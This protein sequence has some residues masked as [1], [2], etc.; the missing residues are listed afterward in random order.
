MGSMKKILNTIF[1]K[2]PISEEVKHKAHVA[3]A[4]YK[5]GK[6]EREDQNGEF[7]I[8]KDTNIRKIYLHHTGNICQNTVNLRHT[9]Q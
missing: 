9:K 1:E 2:L 8:T 5:I 4:E 7:S 3:W 6:E